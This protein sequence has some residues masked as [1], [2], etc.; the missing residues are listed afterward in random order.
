[1]PAHWRN[2]SV[3]MPRH[4]FHKSRV[5]RSISQGIPQSAHCA[6]DRVFEIDKRIDAPKLLLDL[7]P[8]DHFA[9]AFN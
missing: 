3:A 9:S 8:R 5:L 7:F 2:E 6:I 4:G 1:M